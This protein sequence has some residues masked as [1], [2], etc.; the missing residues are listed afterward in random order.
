MRV[1]WF[2]RR[3]HV[4]SYL[5]EWLP[6]V[7]GHGRRIGATVALRDRD[8]YLKEGPYGAILW[9]EDFDKTDQ[10]S[11]LPVPMTLE[12]REAVDSALAAL[13]L[14]ERPRSQHGWLWPSPGKPEQ[15]CSYHFA[16]RQLLKAEALAGLPKLK[17]GIWH[18]YRRRFGTSRKHHPSA[19]VEAVGGWA[20]NSSSLRKCYQL[21]DPDGMLQVV[22][23]GNGSRGKG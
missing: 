17:Q 8:L 2:G 18:P 4:P 20:R 9:P 7:D 12:M 14:G 3:Y 6:I 21:P 19:D 5:P 13:E 23:Q 11:P 15:P 10:E 22:L 1:T 16:E